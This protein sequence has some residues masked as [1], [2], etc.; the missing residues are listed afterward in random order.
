[1]LLGRPGDVSKSDQEDVRE[2]CP[3]CAEELMCRGVLTRRYHPAKPDKAVFKTVSVCMYVKHVNH[4]LTI[5][6][7]AELTCY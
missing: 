4:L 1:M 5:G 2:R 7:I 6:I 3:S